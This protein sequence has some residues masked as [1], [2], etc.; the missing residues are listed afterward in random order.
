MW[1]FHP[2]VGSLRRHTGDHARELPGDPEDDHI[3]LPTNDFLGVCDGPEEWVRA[4]G[5]RITC[6]L[7]C[8]D[9][10]VPWGCRCAPGP[11]RATARE[12]NDEKSEIIPLLEQSEIATLLSLGCSDLLA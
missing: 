11:E 4:A 5:E 12:W 6:R 3:I 1:D 8:L 10:N 9:R 2:R 7:S